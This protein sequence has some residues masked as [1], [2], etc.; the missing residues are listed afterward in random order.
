MGGWRAER[1]GEGEVRRIS[2]QRSF[3]IVGA[4]GSVMNGGRK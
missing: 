2:L 1:E 3:L 4:Y